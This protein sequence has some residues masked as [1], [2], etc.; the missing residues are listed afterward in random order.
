M[1]IDRRVT[2]TRNALYDALVRL[3]LRKDYDAIGIKDILEEADVGRST[4][5]AH[6]TSKDE[7]LARS[8]ERLGK[9]LVDGQR[10]ALAAPAGSSEPFGFSLAMFEHVAGY[11]RLYDTI[12]GTR[13]AAIVREA[14]RDVLITF[15]DDWPGL[16]H[17]EVIPR[18]LAIAHI[19]STFMTVMTWWLERRFS[20]EPREIDAIFRRLANL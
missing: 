6:F 14:Q 13:A 16:R 9:L 15:L 4:F 5:Y 11:K 8:L 12:A 19:A 20:L 10:Q 1:G 18:E 2:R 3:M 7:L 17:D